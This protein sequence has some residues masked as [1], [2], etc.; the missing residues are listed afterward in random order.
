MAD[1][2]IGPLE[3]QIGKVID[4]KTFYKLM[5]M[6]NSGNDKVDK[7]VGATA[8]NLAALTSDGNLKDSG[9]ASEDVSRIIRNTTRVTST[10]YTILSTDYKVFCDTDLIAITVNLPPGEDGVSYTIINSGSSGNNVT[11]VPNGS[12]LLFGANSNETLY[13]GEVFDLTYNTTEGWR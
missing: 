10:P 4:R 11:L 13:N 12:E 7:V 3:H 8:D 9:I 1:N 6:L 5:E 2:V